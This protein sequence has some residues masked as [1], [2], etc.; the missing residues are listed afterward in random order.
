MG[1]SAVI[2][3]PSFIKIG[4]GIQH[5]IRGDTHTHE[6]QRVLISLLHFLNKESKLKMDPK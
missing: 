6:Q 5:L 2:Y 3:E 1:S 4:S